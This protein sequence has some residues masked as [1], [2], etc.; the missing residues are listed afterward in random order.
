MSTT[1]RHDLLQP[2][3]QGQPAGRAPY[4]QTAGFACAFFGGPVASLLLAGLN[5]WRVG[6]W[7]KDLGFLLPA[8]LLWVGLLAALMHTAAGNAVA[9]AVTELAGR[10]GPEL[11][12]QALG[13]A[14]FAFTTLWLHR[15][16][17]R[18]A[19][20]MGLK[21]PNGWWVGLALVVL[22]NGATFGLA[23]WLA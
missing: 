4:S 21:R 17:H 7:P 12:M 10:R 13:L 3:L 2:S 1:I 11:L 22:G 16:E 6:R 23:A 20:L 19:D 18:I 14:Y 5:A 8:A 15:R 9:R